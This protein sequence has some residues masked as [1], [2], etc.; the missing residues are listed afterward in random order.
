MKKSM[1]F[2][3]LLALVAA[4]QFV[5]AGENMSEPKAASHAVLSGVVLD[6]ATGEGLAGATVMIE[7]TQTKAFTDMTGNFSING[8]NPGTYDIKVNYISYEE[9]KLERVNL[10]EKPDPIEIKLVNNGK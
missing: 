5:F 10:D 9:T 2:I 4:F 8:L 6:L 3:S 7:G 1:R